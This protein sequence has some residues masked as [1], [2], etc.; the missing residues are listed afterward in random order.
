MKHL[1]INKNPL[2]SLKYNSGMDGWMMDALFAIVICI[3]K[4]KGALRAVR[5]SQKNKIK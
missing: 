3:M 5:H 1:V 4:L 2:Q